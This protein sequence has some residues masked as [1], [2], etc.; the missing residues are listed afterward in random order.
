MEQQLPIGDGFDRRGG[1]GDNGARKNGGEEA[2]G[3][4]LVAFALVE[5][6]H[7]NLEGLF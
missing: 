2:K 6:V 1:G 7:P 3:I 5:R 4:M